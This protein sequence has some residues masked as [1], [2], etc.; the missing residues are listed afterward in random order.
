M[1]QDRKL[2]RRQALK[3]LAGLAVS[4]PLSFALTVPAGA[5][6][7]LPAPRAAPAFIPRRAGA[8]VVIDARTTEAAGLDPHNVPALANFR[9]THLL[10]EGLTWLDRDLVVQPLLA[11]KWE[12]P[13]PT[14]YVFH[15]RKGVKFHD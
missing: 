2:T 9:V 15:L 1:L 10:Y 11:E 3:G 12:I 7:P 8:G 6:A 4:I 14:T 13:N 5:A